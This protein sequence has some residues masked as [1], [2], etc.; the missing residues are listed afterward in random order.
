MTLGTIYMMTCKDADITDCYIGSTKN[1]KGRI[2]G[3]KCFYNNDC[4]GQ[5]AGGKRRLY[6]TIRE[7]GGWENWVAKPLEEVEFE[8]RRDLLDREHY[9]VKR[10]NSTLNTY[11][12]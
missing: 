12:K 3:H 7:N 2:A 10:L 6:N 8:T 5:G 11:Y 1:F 9:W 4:Y